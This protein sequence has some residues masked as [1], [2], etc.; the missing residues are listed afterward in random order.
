[1]GESMVLSAMAPFPTSSCSRRV[2]QAFFAEPR[3][4]IALGVGCLL[5]GDLA[6]ADFISNWSK[7]PEFPPR[8]VH[9]CRCDHKAACGGAIGPKYHRQV[10][11]D[12]HR[13]DRIR[14]IEDVRWM[15]SSDAAAASHPLES[16]G[17]QS[18]P[19]AVRVAIDRPKA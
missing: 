7:L 8:G 14:V 6:K 10:S 1:M 17:L 2:L 9:H 4:E 3:G 5:Q 19:T 13:P 15:A 18:D 16:V 12:I 11:V